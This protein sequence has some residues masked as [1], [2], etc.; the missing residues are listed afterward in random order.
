MS[1][2]RP[3][4]HFQ[5]CVSKLMTNRFVWSIILYV[6]HYH[7]TIP[8]IRPGRWYQDCVSKLTTY[9]RVQGI[10]DYAK[11][12]SSGYQGMTLNINH[13][14]ITVRCSTLDLQNVRA[15][16]L[17]IQCERTSGIRSRTNAA[18]NHQCH[19]V[20]ML[21]ASYQAATAQCQVLHLQVVILDKKVG[22]QSMMLDTIHPTATAQ[23]QALHLEDVRSVPI[24]K[25][26]THYMVHSTISHVS[27]PVIS[28]TRRR[29]WTPSACHSTVSDI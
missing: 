28:V 13:W 9:H 25:S 3:T 7:G 24:G 6:K 5:D 16:A 20:T 27:F 14:L 18:R 23:R 10:A 15:L 8:K 1:G 11:R 29:C 19:R 4:K 26:S 12:Q 2:F 21:D 17:Q 22:R